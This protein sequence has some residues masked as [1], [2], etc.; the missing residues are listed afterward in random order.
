M[1]KRF[2]E[3]LP[4]RWGLWPELWHQ[5]G[6]PPLSGPDK[7]I[8]QWFVQ[9]CHTKRQSGT[10]P[11][12]CPAQGPKG[13]RLNFRPFSSSVYIQLQKH[14]GPPPSTLWKQRPLFPLWTFTWTA[15]W[16]YTTIVWDT[17]GLRRSPRRH[18]GRYSV[19]QGSSQQP[20]PPHKPYGRSGP[21]IGPVNLKK[22]TSLGPRTSY[23]PPGFSDGH[24]WTLRMQDKGGTKYCGPQTRAP[25]SC[26]KVWPRLRASLSNSFALIQFRSGH[27]G[28]N[29]FLNKVRVPG[30]DFKNCRCGQ[31]RETPWHVLLNC[32]LKEDHR[33][34]LSPDPDFIQL[35]DSPK[36]AAKTAKWIIRSGR[37]CQF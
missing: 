28:L 34:L 10:P 5:H 25:L 4:L 35:L 12:L 27:T 2:R 8:Q 15:G 23:K 29:F 9:H 19:V 22:W 30:I 37:L 20:S 31:G 6:V 7:S 21:L 18:V 13:W 1:P 3:K 24:S 14:T 17:A 26:I 33:H 32:S 16:K 36:R 11:P